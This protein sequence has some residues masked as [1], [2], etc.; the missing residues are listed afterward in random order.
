M[1]YSSLG[2]KIGLEIHQQLDTKKL[3]CNCESKLVDEIGIEFIRALRPTQSELG[4]LDKAAVEEAKKKLLFKY[5][6]ANTCLVEADEEP[7]HLANIDAINIAIEVSLL[8]NAKILDEIHFMRKIVID[9]SNTAGFQRTALV[10]TDGFI[11][12]SIGKVGIATICLE[13]DAARKI[14]TEEGMVIYRLDRLGIPLVEIAT[15]PDIKTPEHAKEVAKKIGDFLRATGKVKRGLGTIRQ[16][17]NISI[18][19][20]ARVELKGVQD[21]KSIPNVI[22]Q[23]IKRQ[24]NLI[25]IKNELQKRGVKN[26]KGNILD[27]SDIFRNTE[28]QIIKK[29]KNKVFGLRLEGFKGLIGSKFCA[30]P[31]NKI[32]FQHK[33]RLGREFAQ[34]VKVKG[35]RGIFHT[36]ELP[37]YGISKREVEEVNKTLNIKEIDAFVLVAENEKKA[38]TALNIILERARTAI[39]K[40]PEEVRRVNPDN[41]TEYMRPMPGSA[42]MYPET[43]VPPIRIN[44]ERIEKIKKNLPELLKDK[45]KRFVKEYGI[46]EEQAKQLIN[47]NS[48][49]AFEDYVNLVMKSKMKKDKFEISSIVAKA[50]LN[51]LPELKREGLLIKNEKK[52]LNEIFSLFAEGKLAKEGVEE[53]LIY[54]A[55][56]ECEVDKAISAL[57][58]GVLKHKEI[59]NIIKNIIKEREEFVKKKGM[60]SLGPI[61][62]VLM[63]ELR[64]KADGKLLSEILKKEILKIIEN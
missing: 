14:G 51:S 19:G 52:V 32:N 50:I 53:I 57:G 10:A 63:K 40:L 33:H 37:S 41:T 47:T 23:E 13:E 11:D 64:G 56:N 30:I 36:D 35:I 17:L 38:K 9:G 42:R 18:N 15:K 25:E 49:N 44:R 22:E 43:D 48:F 61:M 4:E 62:G 45:E 8:L 29:M 60:A 2:L 39:K 6:T 12:S 3:F 58:F 28:C 16:D 59:E 34:Y 55:K 27:V 21:L 31:K 1:N 7:P 24:L 54:V 26:L 5:Q 20:G 46:S